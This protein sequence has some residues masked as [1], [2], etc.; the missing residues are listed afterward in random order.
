M[1]ECIN[2]YNLIAQEYTEQT[3]RTNKERHHADRCMG[4]WNIDLHVV[5]HWLGVESSS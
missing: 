1:A 5:D 3:M 4:L 2:H